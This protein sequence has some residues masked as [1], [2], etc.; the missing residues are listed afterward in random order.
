MQATN[1]RPQS[2][3]HE[4]TVARLVKKFSDFMEPEV[5]VPHLIQPA[6]GFCPMSGVYSPHPFALESILNFCP[7]IPR[8]PS[9]LFL[10][11]FEI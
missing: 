11:V 4:I 8:S 2:Q 1:C 10:E 7:S 3:F 5:L 6:S 9:S